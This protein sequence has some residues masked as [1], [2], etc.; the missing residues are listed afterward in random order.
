MDTVRVLTNET[1]NQNCSFCDA[2]RPVERPSF[3]RADAVLAR[4]DAAARAGAREIVLTGGEPT[5]RRDLPLLVARAHAARATVMLETNAALITNSLA[6]A[7]AKAGLSAAR[8]HLPAWGEEADVISRDEGGFARTLEGMAALDRAGITVEVAAP[9]VRTNVARLSELPARLSGE[10]ASIAK[11]RAL[12]LGVPVRAPDPST[13][14]SIEEAAQ[15]IEAV[16]ERARSVGLTVRLD[17]GSLIP[18][19]AFSKPSRVAHIFS[20]T[21]GGALAPGYL[22]PPACEACSVGDR[23]PGVPEEALAR[24]PPFVAR[25]LSDERTRRR[26]SLVTGVE[27]QI[28]R[29]LVTRDVH[30]MRDGTTVPEHIVRINFHCNQACRFCFV[31][32]HLPPAEDSAVEA[33][34]AEIAGIGGVLSLSGGEPTLNPRLPELVAL[35]KRLGAR[36]IELQTNAI[37][38]AD[39][40]LSRE[41]AVAGV[42]TAFVSLHASTAALSDRITEAPGTFDRTVKGID[43]ARRAGISVRLNFVFCEANKGDFPSYIAM[44]AARWPGAPVTVSHVAASTDVVPLSTSLIP[45]YSDLMPAL[46]EGARLAKRLGVE[47][48]G[49][50]S[51]CGIPLCMVPDDLSPFFQLSDAPPDGGEFVKGEVCSSCALTSRCFGVRRGYAELYGTSELKP[52][53]LA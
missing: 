22:R 1:C 53:R 29:E 11:V 20:L 6:E 10:A 51:M 43:E 47:L 42:D 52:C 2:R 41:L 14:V 30:R 18:P 38:L 45:R 27:E 3:A 21:R 36:R 40:S 5:L 19:C 25:P 49:F 35:G 16:V 7:L 50:E 26:L 33:A 8:V 17:A 13:L 44:V 39:P 37:R 31:S 48:L 32:T 9:V 46:S 28:A 4:I 23:C 34:I 12:I 15:V 24:E